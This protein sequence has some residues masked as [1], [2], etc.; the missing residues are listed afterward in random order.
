MKM[1]AVKNIKDNNYLNYASK[2]KKF[3]GKGFKGYST[4]S[5]YPTLRPKEHIKKHFMKWINNTFNPE[6]YVIV[7]FT[8]LEV[9]AK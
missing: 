3:I 5:P 8:E 1:Y 6:D 7:E 4:S 2:R 9:K